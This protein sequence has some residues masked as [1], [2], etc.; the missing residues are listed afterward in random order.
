MTHG[1]EEDKLKI[2]REL[3]VTV[4]S[5]NLMLDRG[6]PQKTIPNSIMIPGPHAPKD[7]CE[8]ARSRLLNLLGAQISFGEQVGSPVLFYLGAFVYA[9]LDLRTSLSDED[10]AI[11]VSFGIQ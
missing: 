3:L 1:T 11:S 6:N 10:S 9:I 5:G 8:K 4:A 7:G 2:K